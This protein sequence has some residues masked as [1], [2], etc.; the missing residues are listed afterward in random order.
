MTT[1]M[2]SRQQQQQQQPWMSWSESISVA[3]TGGDGYSYRRSASVNSVQPGRTDVRRR[4]GVRLGLSLSPSAFAES[5]LCYVGTSAGSSS[6]SS[7]SRRRRHKSTVKYDGV[8][9]TARRYFETWFILP[10]SSVRHLSHLEAQPLG[11]SARRWYTAAL[12]LVPRHDSVPESP[13]VSPDGSSFRQ[14]VTSSWAADDNNNRDVGGNVI[15]SRGSER[16]TGD[17]SVCFRSRVVV[18]VEPEEP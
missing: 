18:Q 9:L 14:S 5:V 16:I 1:V 4:E 7:S 10:T 13:P 6:C 17:N 2:G 11:D 12:K 3:S 15:R 8:G